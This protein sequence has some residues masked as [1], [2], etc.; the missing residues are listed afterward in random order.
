MNKLPNRR[1]F[2]YDMNKLLGLELPAVPPPIYYIVSGSGMTDVNGGY[3][4]LAVIDG[5]PCFVRGLPAPNEGD[6]DHLV[7]LRRN[8]S[9][10]TWEMVDVDITIDDSGDSPDPD[11]ILYT[12]PSTADTPPS[13]GWVVSNGS[14]PA[15]TDIAGGTPPPPDYIVS[16]AGS[17]EVNG[18]YRKVLNTGGTVY[19]Y[20][21]GNDANGQFMRNDNSMDWIM[22]SAPL[23]AYYESLYYADTHDQTLPLTGWDV[24]NG[25]EPVPTITAYQ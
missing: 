9:S 13:S 4:Q 25:D 14:G 15:P 18:E 22:T 2:N 8:A 6:D 10:H 23:D 7:Y 1:N 12:N 16:G 21:C 24:Y 19:G 17:P 11:V 20:V 3:I 5:V